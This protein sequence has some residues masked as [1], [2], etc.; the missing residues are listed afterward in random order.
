MKTCLHTV[1]TL[2]II[3]NNWKHTMSI[4]RRMA[5]QIMVC[6]FYGI[7]LSNIKEQ[8]TNRPSKM[9]ES[10]NHAERTKL[11]IKEYVL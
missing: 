11:N 5:K 8:N 4:N 1:A 9:K 7:Q 6:P 10:K 2:F 3:N